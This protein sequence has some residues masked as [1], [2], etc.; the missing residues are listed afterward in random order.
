M[1]DF[2]TEL[3]STLQSQPDLASQTE[4]RKSPKLFAAI[5]E[6]ETQC[7]RFDKCKEV[8]ELYN[9]NLNNYF[10]NHLLPAIKQHNPDSEDHL[11]IIL[12]QW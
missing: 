10:S 8:Y 2:I 11:K 6:V 9:R 5:N 3:T 12:Q 4:L 7:D 1:S